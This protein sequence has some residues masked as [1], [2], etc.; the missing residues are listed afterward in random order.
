MLVLHHIH[1]LIRQ[2][3]RHLRRIRARHIAVEALPLGDPG[4]RGLGQG[5][6]A[7]VDLGCAFADG[8]AVATEAEEVVAVRAAGLDEVLGG[9]S[10]LIVGA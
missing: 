9:V 3:A 7:F 6:H 2:N 4:A 10:R 8:F 1:N 5:D